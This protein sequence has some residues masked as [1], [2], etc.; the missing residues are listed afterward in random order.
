L[1]GRQE[2]ARRASS[3]GEAEHIMRQKSLAKHAPESIRLLGRQVGAGKRADRVP[4]GGVA[5]REQAAR[6]AR[7]S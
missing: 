2:G 7:F 6:E 1:P 3:Q 4:P 5:R